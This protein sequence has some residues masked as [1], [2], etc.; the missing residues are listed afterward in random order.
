MTAAAG[1]VDV[2]LAPAATKWAATLCRLESE[3]TDAR[4][5]LRATGRCEVAERPEEPWG[6]YPGY[7]G[8]DPCWR[9]LP[10]EEWCAACSARQ[11]LF[12]RL[13]ALRAKAKNA[14]RRMVAAW[15]RSTP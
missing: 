11:P 12:D 10:Q 1:G 3:L 4:R 6:A 8:T 14:K 15:R 9:I 7:D 2:R 5:E 13:S